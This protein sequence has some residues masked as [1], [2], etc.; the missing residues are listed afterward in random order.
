MDNEAFER[1]AQSIIMQAARDYHNAFMA[2]KK[3]A[4]NHAAQDNLV[5]LRHF[6]RTRWYKCLTG[7]PGELL[8]RKLEE[9]NSV[10]RIKVINAQNQN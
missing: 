8:M 3:D 4:N 9:Q 10:R 5:E 7:I 6:F 1:L 2:V